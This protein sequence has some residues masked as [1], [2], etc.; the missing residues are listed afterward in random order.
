VTLLSLVIFL[1]GIWSL[2]LFAGRMLHDDLERLLSDQQFSTATIVAAEINHELVFRLRSLEKVAEK[3]VPPFFSNPEQLQA[4]LENRPLLDT[5]FNGGVFI[6]RKDGSVTASIPHSIDRIGINYSERDYIVAALRYGKTSV[7]KPV[8]GKALHAPVISMA[9]PVRN[10]QGAVIGA[11][12][13]VIDLSKSSFLDYITS[14]RYGK[15]GDFFLVASQHRMIVTGSD[16]RRVMEQLPAHGIIPQIDNFIAGFEGTKS[17]I[18][19]KGV[20]ALVSVKKVPAAGW[21]LAAL[22]P[23]SEAFAPVRAMQ[24]RMLIAAIVLTFLVGG[25][26]WLM[27]R[28]QLSPLFDAVN[29]L[30]AISDENLPVTPLAVTGTDEVG[31]LIGGFNRMLDTL[32]LREKAL[33]ESDERHRSILRTATSGIWLNDLQGRLLEVNNAYCRMS[34]YSE[35]ELLTMNISDLEVTESSHDVV[36]H[37][38]LIKDRGDVCFESQHRR[39]DG[40]VFD[41]EVSVQYRPT[42]GGQCVAFV[43]DITERKRSVEDLVRSEQ[44]LKNAQRVAGMGNWGLDV[45]SGKLVW[46]DEI[47]RIFEIDPDRFAASYDS[48]LDI[49][50]P[51]DR[52]AVNRAYTESLRNRVP[53]EISHRLLMADGRVK[54]VLEKCETYFDQDGNPLRSIGTVQDVT[55]AKRTEEEKDLLESQLQQAQKLESVGRLAGGVAHDFNNMLT[56]INGYSQLGVMDSDSDSP[57]RSY[58]E[59]ISRTSD[60]SADLTRQ[61]LAFARK[62]AVVPRE[63]NLNETVH[64]MLKMLHRLIGESIRLA[65]QP[66][67]DLWQVKADPSQIDQIL[68]NLCVNARDAITDIGTITIETANRIIDGKY[69]QAHADI[70]SGQYVAISVSDTGCGIDKDVLP[71]IFEPFFTTK[72]VGEGTGLGLAT[73][74]GIAKQN[75]GFVNVYS[76]PGMGTTFTIY[77]PRHTGD[78]PQ[79]HAESTCDQLPTGCETVLL[80]EDESAILTLTATMLEKHGYTVLMTDSPFEAIQMGRDH[81]D[82]INLLITD[83]IMPEMNGRDLSLQLQQRDPAIKCLFMSGYTADIIAQHGVLEDGVFFI[84]KPFTVSGLM[85]KV[86]EVLDDELPQDQDV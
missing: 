67:P 85:R 32:A 19:P 53:Y 45:T 6:T 56:I 54:F 29:K 76:E 86:R 25:V 52:E 72:K 48:F 36:E 26:T 41:V 9:T 11:L 59:E 57:L 82:R 3:V 16:K 50:H 35:Q 62:Q 23:V 7:G 49:I 8:I 15:S 60:R 34:G 39:K 20:E 30:S 77:L 10:A 40:A 66:A 27:L 78:S 63:L 22:L 28:R 37:L 64:G 79:I 61:L 38:Q 18:N 44:R 51:D 55:R 71:H 2:E 14:N 84:Q 4:L 75:N 42:E 70:Q 43:Q 33:Q 24:Q 73:V 58:F 21:Y 83:V 1:A 12:V 47:F 69:V 13:G 81:V 17:F 65:W 68:A 46:S 31:Q 80:V 74:Y 5:L